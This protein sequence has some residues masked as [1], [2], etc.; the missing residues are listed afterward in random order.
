MS[1]EKYQ[2]KSGHFFPSASA[3][4]TSRPEAG[5]TTTTHAKGYVAGDTETYPMV[6]LKVSIERMRQCLKK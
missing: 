2:A 4:E 3:M 5:S 6:E 1:L